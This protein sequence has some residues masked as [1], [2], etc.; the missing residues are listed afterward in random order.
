MATNPNPIA[1][2]ALLKIVEQVKKYYCE[3]PPKRQRGRPR[4]F[5]SLA[6]LLL[7]VVGVVLRTFK[8]QELVTLLRK[9]ASLRQALGFSRLPHRR[10]IERRLNATRPEAEAQGQAL[11]HQILAE[12][13]PAPDQP[14]AS[15]IDGRMYQAQGPL[16]H[17]RDREAARIPLGLRNVDTASTWSKS[18][19]RGWVQGYRLVLQGLVF[20]A[21]VPLFARWCPNA[22]GESTVLDE[23]L[24]AE[25]LP[26]TELLLGDATF[27]G[28]DLVALY[29]KHGGWLLTPQQL[30][31][32]PDAWQ[33]ELFAYR[34]E[35]IELLFERLMQACDLKVCPA[36]GLARTGTFVIA[37]VWLYQVLFLD[38]YRHHRP[39]AHIKEII[40]E[41]RWR[42]AA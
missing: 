11:G 37:S 10:T 4:T 8:P 17:K 9:D 29:A 1:P 15:A 40:D 3:P 20:P 2:D 35:T 6:F 36:K 7:A 19:Y 18:G 21:P 38:N 32:N 22:V 23:A 5:S 16:W 41:G 12:V 28:A 27:G 26:V 24:R 14:L 25:Q 39:V 34:R 13:E 31:K 30:P 42:I 33:R